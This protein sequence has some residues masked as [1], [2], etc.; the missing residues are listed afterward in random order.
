MDFIAY[1]LSNTII[2]QL[3]A[4]EWVVESVEYSV[5]D[6]RLPCKCYYVRVVDCVAVLFLVMISFNE[7]I[8]KQ[9]NKFN[10]L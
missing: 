4:A 8:T 10:S 5:N 7:V 3:F 9:K 2:Y 1:I 6:V